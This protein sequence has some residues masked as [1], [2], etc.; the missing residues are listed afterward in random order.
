MPLPFCSCPM[1]LSHDVSYDIKHI[2]SLSYLPNRTDPHHHDARL[3]DEQY[4]PVYH[5][6]RRSAVSVAARPLVSSS[7]V[8]CTSAGIPDVSWDNRLCV[9]ICVYH[10][11]Y[12]SRGSPYNM[13]N[14]RM[15]VWHVSDSLV[16][17]ITFHSRTFC[18]NLST[19]RA[20]SNQPQR[21]APSTLTRCP[22]ARVMVTPRAQEY[23]L[24]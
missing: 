20:S 1:L 9:K 18:E 11:I 3:D 22:G 12:L 24:V 16:Y 10:S 4:R 15:D 7:G 5:T 23:F 17:P 13:T 8:C 2:D 14:V 6:S 21:Y 19:A